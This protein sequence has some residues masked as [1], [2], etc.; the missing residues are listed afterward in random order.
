MMY[1]DSFEA[2]RL[3]KLIQNKKQYLQKLTGKAYQHLQ[4]EIMFL[5]NDI[6]RN[7]NIIHSEFARYTVICFETALKYKCNGVIFYV[8]INENY[9]DRPIIGIANERQLTEEQTKVR[10]SILDRIDNYC[11][12]SDMASNI[13]LNFENALSAVIDGKPD[14]FKKQEIKIDKARGCIDFLIALVAI[15]GLL[16]GI[17]VLFL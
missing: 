1:V 7:T 10:I 12:V 2:E 5:E 16:Y 15:G 3:K 14:E 4:Q 6:L 8:P 9:E 13:A 11:N 17:Y